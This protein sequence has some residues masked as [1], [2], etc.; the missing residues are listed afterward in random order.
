[1]AAVKIYE[2]SYDTKNP[3][4]IF[5]VVLL[6]NLGKE[7]FFLISS[8]ICFH[9]SWHFWKFS[10]NSAENCFVSLNVSFIVR[11]GTLWVRPTALNPKI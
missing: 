2:Y 4:F 3:N 5:A 1:M 11:I 6:T 9:D 7:V 8:S 10:S